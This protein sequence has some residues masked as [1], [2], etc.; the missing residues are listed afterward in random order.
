MASLAEL[1][2]ELK[3][4]SGL[5][6]GV[7]AKRLHM[8]TSTLHRYCNG[9]AVPAEFAPVERLARLCKASPEELVEVH[10]RWILA[11]ADRGR[12]AELAA[13]SAPEPE[14]EPDSDSDSEP[15]TGAGPARATASTSLS[16]SRSRSSSHRR[17]TLVLA[18]AFAAVVGIGSLAL[19]VNGS[20]DGDQHE[21][22]LGSTAPADP[23]ASPSDRPGKARPDG[24]RGEDSG[25]P[26]TARTRPYA[27]KDDCM[28]EFLVNRRP[29]EVPERPTAQDAPGWVGD[30]GAVSARNQYI[31]VTV[32]G[33]GKDTVVLQ[34]MNVRVQSSGAPLAWNNF[35]M[36]SGC[37]GKADTKAFTVD[38][39]AATPSVTQKD[40]RR[41]FPY[42]VS[43]N[44]SEVFYI[45]ANADLHDVRW[46]LELEWSSG[47]RHDVLRIDDQGKPFRTSGR[48]GRPSYS[49]WGEWERELQEDG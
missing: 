10:R 28:Q 44:D 39:D 43:E 24:A 38:L 27:Y 21:Q 6:Y 19:A 13:S 32:Q 3:E 42:K 18:A 20:G 15:A 12:K 17:R 4:R 47:K 45:A 48:E 29:D 37:G 26:L 35:Q 2:R 16:P 34:G 7:L 40:D 14:P 31:E 36:G 23:S 46:Y 22:S 33:M 9:N 11:D 41:D 25:T 1:L 8:S 5:S 49:W 30:L